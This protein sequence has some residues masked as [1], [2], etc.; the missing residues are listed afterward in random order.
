[1]TTFSVTASG[2]ASRTYTLQHRASLVSGL[3]EDIKSV[4]P[5]GADGT[6]YLTDDAP[7]A[8]AGFYRLRVT[9]P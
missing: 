2:K 8:T 5:L 1:M 7:P 3:W 4:G 6:V 9:A